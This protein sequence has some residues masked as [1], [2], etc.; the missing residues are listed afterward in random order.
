MRHRTLLL[1][2]GIGWLILTS[3]RVFLWTNDAALWADAVQ[4]AP[5]KPRPWLHY[6]AAIV[7]TD[8]IRAASAFQRAR[9]LAER[10]TRSAD[11]R[12][13][14]L[15]SAEINLA[16][17]ARR[18]GRLQETKELMTAARLRAPHSSAIEARYAW[19]LDTLR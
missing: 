17:L 4:R 6:G 19:L 18:A 5:E 11:E 14:D 2:V 3:Q 15:A 16:L 7:H 8:A 13:V 10:P 1:L 12:Q 9:A